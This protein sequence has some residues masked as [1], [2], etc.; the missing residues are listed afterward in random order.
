MTPDERV[1]AALRRQQPDRVPVFLYLNPWAK[2]WYNQDPSY[3]DVLAACAEYE[4]VVYDWG[5]PQGLFF[6]AA[7]VETANRDLGGGHTET[8][9]RTPAGPLTT[10]SRKDW[11]GGGLVKRW[12]TKVAD[13]ERALY[14]PYVPP[15]PDLS[16]FFAERERLKGRAVAQVTFADPICCAGWIEEETLAIWTIEERPLLKRFL[17][18]MYQRVMD[19]L[20]YCLDKGVG[21]I[22]YFNGP[23]YA[24]PPLMSPRDFD[25][26]VVEYDRELIRL[27]HSYPGMYTIIHSHGRVNNFLERF[28]AIG[29]DGLNV[30]EP[31]PIGDVILADAKR[32]VGERMCLIGNIQYDDLARG[33]AHEIEA[34]VRDAIRQGGPGGGFILS[35]CA[36]PYE[37]PLPPKASA[38]LIHY[39]KMGRRYGVYPLNV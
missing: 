29:T 5:F 3:A 24:L 37:R 33:S 18:A 15:R 9:W 28:V 39:L 30:L 27:I 11:R 16:P 14:I 21:P 8:T 35:P 22:C 13:V 4:D 34:L 6:T 25:E 12:I 10:V 38:N 32:R 20:R 2:N 17:D 7:K 19:H 26:F 36:S 23:E 31:P 1:L